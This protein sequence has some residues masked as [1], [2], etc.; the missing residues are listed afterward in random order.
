LRFVSLIT[1]GVASSVRSEPYSCRQWLHVLNVRWIVR[2]PF[3]LH[4]DG[5]E[6]AAA[7]IVEIRRVLSG[8]L[9]LDVGARVAHYAQ[10]IL[11]VGPD[12]SHVNENV[13]KGY[14]DVASKTDMRNPIL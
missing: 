2:L 4:K 10:S 9:F 14:F 11:E 5:E 3:E 8:T 1:V 6:V 12:I 7:D 13:G